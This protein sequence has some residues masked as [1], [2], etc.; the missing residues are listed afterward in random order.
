MA[1]FNFNSMVRAVLTGSI[2]FDT[3]SF[4]MLLVTSA[5]DETA[6]DTFDFRNDIVNEVAN[7]NGYATGGNAVTL[8]VAAVDTANNDV[9]I[10]ASAVSWAA[11]TIAAAGAVIYKSRGGASSADEVICFLDFGATIS[12]TSGTFTVTPTASIKFQN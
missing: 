4:K 9:E 8:T 12:S 3:D 2:D 7:G 6:K 1:S 11:S 5:L 10:T